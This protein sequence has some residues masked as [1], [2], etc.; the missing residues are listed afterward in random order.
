M[1]FELARPRPVKE[2]SRLAG[3]PCVAIETSPS[4]G[5]RLAI[6]DEAE[7]VDEPESARGRCG[8]VALTSGAVPPPGPFG[9]KT[10]MAL[11]NIFLSAARREPGTWVLGAR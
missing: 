2:S 10:L 11:S 6:D 7:D 4:S 3:R 5:G 8:S 9:T 1:K